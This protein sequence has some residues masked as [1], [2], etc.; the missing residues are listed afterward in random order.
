M[1]ELT[2][3]PEMF[4]LE[5]MMGCSQT[6]SEG[7]MQRLAKYGHPFNPV[8]TRFEV[9]VYF[10]Y[11]LSHSLLAYQQEREV[12]EHMCVLCEYTL[13]RR[14]SEVISCVD[15]G[16]LI[17][18]RV[19]GYARI[20]DNC[21]ASGNNPHTAW[22]KALLGHIAA[23][24]QSN[25]VEVHHAVITGDLIEEF[26]SLA[27]MV[28]FDVRIAVASCCGLKHICRRAT[29]FRTL[30]S[31]EMFELMSR[32]REEAWEIADSRASETMKNPPQ[33]KKR[34]WSFYG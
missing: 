15:L 27:V 21:Q 3:G 2:T 13:C 11:L 1:E 22:I 33:R 28:D 29:D 30:S 26:L 32:G 24:A 6:Y 18:A 5:Y 23:S 17:A 7:L 16:D 4:I 10:A 14:H 9:D 19:E 25:L 8:T 34:W 12:W 20:L 31:A